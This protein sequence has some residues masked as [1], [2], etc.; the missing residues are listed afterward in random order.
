MGKIEWPEGR[1]ERMHGE[2]VRE[3]GREGGREGRSVVP[4]AIR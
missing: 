3:G 4:G 1:E 2:G